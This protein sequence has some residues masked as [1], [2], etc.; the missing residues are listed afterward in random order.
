V[1]TR[2]VAT[3]T[4]LTASLL[5]GGA[6]LAAASPGSQAAQDQG[7]VCEAWEHR[8]DGLDTALAQMERRRERLS[9]ALADAQA[10]GDARRVRRIETQLAQVD[11]VVARLTTAAD[12]LNDAYDARCEPFVQPE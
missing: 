2:Q 12:R 7:D 8:L 9:T 4:V 5:F 10:D 1:N 11:R 6:G 3:G